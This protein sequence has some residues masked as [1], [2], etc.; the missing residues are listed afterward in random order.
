MDNDN[1][2]KAG[3]WDMQVHSYKVLILHVKWYDIT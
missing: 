2:T 1:N 3:S